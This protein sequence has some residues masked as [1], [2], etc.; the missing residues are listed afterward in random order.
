MVP[1]VACPC[2]MPTPKPRSW[3][4][5][6]H[7][8]VNVPIAARISSAACTAWSAGSGTGTGS[9]N[10]TMTPSPAYRSRVPLYLIMIS[11]MAAWYS[12]SSAIT[13][14]GSELSE[15]PV[16][17]S[18]S[19]Q[20]AGSG[21]GE[22]HSVGGRPHQR[23]RLRSRAASRLLLEIDVASAC[24]LASRT[25]K[26][27]RSSSG[28]GLRRRTRGGRKWRGRLGSGA[29]RALAYCAF[30]FSDGLGAGAEPVGAAFFFFFF[31]FGASLG[32]WASGCW[33]SAFEAVSTAAGTAKLAARP[34]RRNSFRREIT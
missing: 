13:S 26:H 25:I 1:S 20:G 8:S 28:S 14:S 23:P 9:L 34:I 30:G 3:P 17:I 18:S 6:L 10:T 15:K 19:V 21:A 31:F 27:R 7:F 24:P 11:P 22:R 2:A 29:P 12:R 16:I 32:C 4:S 5:R 33:A